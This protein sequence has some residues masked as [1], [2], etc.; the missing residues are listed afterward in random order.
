M[1]R[2]LLGKWIGLVGKVAA[3]CG[4]LVQKELSHYIPK[5]NERCSFARYVGFLYQN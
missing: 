5:R 3:T 2:T 4:V 1:A